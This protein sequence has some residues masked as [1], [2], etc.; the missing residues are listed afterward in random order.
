[1]AACASLL[2]RSFEQRLM[3][4][5]FRSYVGIVF[6]IFI[7]ACDDSADTG[8]PDYGGDVTSAGGV[9]AVGGGPASAGALSASGA[10]APGGA[11]QNSGGTSGGGGTPSGGIGGGA[12]DGGPR[13]VGDVP[14]VPWVAG[15]CA[16]PGSNSTGFE[17]A[18]FCVR[19]STSS[20]T[21]AAL[22]PKASPGF[23]FTP[24]DQL[25]ERSAAGYVHLGDITLRLRSD[26]AGEWRNVTT[27]ASRNA[28]TALTASGSVLAAA[29]LAPALPSDLPIGVTR[30][31]SMER[32]RLVMRFD[33]A[34]RSQAPVQIG[35]LGL[36]MVFNNVLTRR[37]LEQAH[38]TCSFADPYI[39]ADAGYLQVTRL[40]GKGP[41]LLV[42][43]DGKTSFE[44]YNPILNA[45][46]AGSK[47]PVALFTD[48]TPRGTSFE[49]FLEW[50]VHSKA[51]AEKEWA[52]AS[53][54]NPPTDVTLAP[55]E[56][57]TYGVK[58]VL[59][60]EVRK[61]EGLLAEN[62]RPV[63]VGIPGYVLPTDVEGKLF[64]D[65][66]WGVTSI[67]VEPPGALTVTE[68]A[69]TNPRYVAYT[70]SGKSHG[71]ARVSIAY[72]DGTIQ[73]IHY[74]VIA[75]AKE[76][77]SKLGTFLTTKAWFV[78][79][80][81]PFGRS[82]S[83]MTYDHDL[84]EVV[85]QSKQA[86]VC[87]LGDD[88][89][90]TWLAG[91][92][93]LFGQPS[94]TQAAQY[95]QFVDGVVWGNLQYSSGALKWASNGRSSIT[96]PRYCLPATTARACNGSIQSPAPSTGARGT[97]CTR[98]RSPARTT[99]RTLPR[100]IGPSTGSRATTRASSRAIR[101]IGI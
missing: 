88:G 69:S 70:V 80:D 10:S 16:T 32:G 71:R 9:W 58:F 78:D 50:M 67:A 23:D 18:E 76:A 40:N 92:M 66:P 97:G 75:P 1:M 4:P 12:P 93:K 43:P 79:N 65:Y 86:W 99:I 62:H 55:G 47:D 90:A 19:L 89:G 13:V 68:H 45:P 49:G 35:A 30:S 39:G 22:A 7:A 31:W 5:L 84:G 56:S 21:I 72:A 38:E 77:V 81:D 100:S 52:S 37:T 85:T 25:A 27:A 3:R 36:P 44:A 46:K 96:S 59:A 29:D 74:D 14:D 57:K 48:P 82:P 41:V 34:N 101:G 83:V 91:A 51:Y 8:V 94:S 42:L 53:P 98:S 54:W 6:A 61:V 26:G 60:P 63:A 33:L 11:A 20:Q 73:A 2:L 24:A 95:E 64:L 17:T 87:G 28:V 15:T